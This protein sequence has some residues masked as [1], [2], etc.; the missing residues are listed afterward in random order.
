MRHVNHIKALYRDLKTQTSLK[1]HY[2][3]MVTLSTSWCWGNVNP[4]T[5]LSG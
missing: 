3:V 5:R 1:A 4:L 2:F